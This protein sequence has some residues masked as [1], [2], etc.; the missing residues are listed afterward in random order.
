MLVTNSLT[1]LC[2]AFTAN[3]VTDTFIATVLLLPLLYV[4]R[5]R[6]LVVVSYHFVI[7]VHSLVT[8]RLSE[9]MDD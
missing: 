8:D 6:K 7:S 5:L 4:Y 9:T 1:L 3:R 2:I